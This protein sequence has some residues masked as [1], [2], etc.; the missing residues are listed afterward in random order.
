MVRWRWG[1]GEVDVGEWCG[2]CGGGGVM[3]RRIIRLWPG[4]VPTSEKIRHGNAVVL[5]AAFKAIQSNRLGRWDARDITNITSDN[6][7]SSAE[8]A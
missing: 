6:N 5:V 3:M 7:N 4:L 2:G 1:N 8:A